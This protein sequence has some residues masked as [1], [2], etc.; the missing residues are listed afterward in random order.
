MA[1]PRPDGSIE[2]LQ[3]GNRLVVSFDRVRWSTLKEVWIIYGFYCPW[4][5]EKSLAKREGSRLSLRQARR[6]REAVARS[7]GMGH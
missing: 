5:E 4:Y 6:L 1:A 7:E 3:R 2:R